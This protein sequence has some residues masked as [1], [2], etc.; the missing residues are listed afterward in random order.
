MDSIIEGDAYGLIKNV[1][2]KSVDLIVTDP[3]YRITGISENT[4][5]FRR[6]KKGHYVKEINDAELGGGVFISI[7]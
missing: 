2:D 6:R 1:P 5:L 3:P 4:G 7:S